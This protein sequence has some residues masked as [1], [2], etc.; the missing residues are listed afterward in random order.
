[1]GLVTVPSAM[2]VKADPNLAMFTAPSAIFAVLTV[3]SP[4]VAISSCCPNTTPK[5]LSVEA[6][7]VVYVMVAAL[8]VKS[9]PGSWITPFRLIIRASARTGVSA[10]PEFTNKLKVVVELLKLPDISSREL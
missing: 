1:M 2:S 9:A 6:G 4:G 3:P 8:T 5:K 7:A 10:V